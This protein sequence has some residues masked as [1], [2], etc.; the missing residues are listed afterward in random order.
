MLFY[1]VSRNNHN[2]RKKPIFSCVFQ[3]GENF[4]PKRNF[5]ILTLSKNTLQNLTV[6][7]AKANVPNITTVR[8]IL[9]Y[10]NILKR[11][12][13]RNYRISTLNAINSAL[14]LGRVLL[15]VKPSEMKI[16]QCQQKI[17]I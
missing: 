13:L 14:H 8:N 5:K 12:T 2:I 16:I 9:P 3:H 1:K 6:T 11:D 15:K 17:N 7:N 10:G 4:V